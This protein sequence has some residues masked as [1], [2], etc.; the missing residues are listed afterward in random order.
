MFKAIKDGRKKYKLHYKWFT[1]RIDVTDIRN[2]SV[3]CLYFFSSDTSS[4]IHPGKA[5]FMPDG[6]GSG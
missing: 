1:Y 4:F 5:T 2:L 3:T 6:D